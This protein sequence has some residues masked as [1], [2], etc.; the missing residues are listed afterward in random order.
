ML[1][2]KTKKGGKPLISRGKKL[3]GA[4]DIESLVQQAGDYFVI[5]LSTDEAL[6]LVEPY[7][8]YFEGLFPK[9]LKHSSAGDILSSF[10]ELV[11]NAVEHGNKRKKDKKIKI[12][13][14]LKE[15]YFKAKIEDE[16]DGFDVKDWFEWFKLSLEFKKTGK[17]HPGP[18][19]SRWSDVGLAK[20]EKSLLK[21]H[22]AEE[23][24]ERASTDKHDHYHPPLAEGKGGGYGLVMA[25]SNLHMICFNE[26][27]NQVTMKTY[28]NRKLPTLEDIQMWD[29]VGKYT[30]N[31]L[32]ISWRYMPKTNTKP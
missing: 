28:F 32:Y 29:V 31:S 2:F 1:N 26:K 19:S 25:M 23:A 13:Y 10:L 8:D 20:H 12:S 27:G 9:D 6:T 14:Q 24:A 3:A 21:Y 7:Y 5:N 11:G 22:T 16:G 30:N 15:G 17:K 4:K 18:T